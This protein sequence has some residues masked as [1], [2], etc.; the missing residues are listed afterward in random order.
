MDYGS[1]SIVEL[2]GQSLPFYTTQNLAALTMAKEGLV[3]TSKD[4]QRALNFCQVWIWNGSSDNTWNEPSCSYMIG[5]EIVDLALG[6]MLK[7]LYLNEVVAVCM[8]RAENKWCT[9]QID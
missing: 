6:Y 7:L 4:L 5:Y 2:W 3:Q 8:T 9:G 1:V